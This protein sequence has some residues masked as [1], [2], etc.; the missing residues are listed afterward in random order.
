MAPS[1]LLVPNYSSMAHGDAVGVEPSTPSDGC[2]PVSARALKLP[3]C[4]TELTR[5]SESG[6]AVK[7]EVFSAVEVA[8]LVE[9]V[10]N[11]GV[12]CDEFLQTSRSSEAQLCPFSSSKR[13][14]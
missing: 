12:N 1:F 3:F 9:M 11:G 8:F 5:L 4:R 13:Q 14:V 10:V 2:E 6:G 7:L